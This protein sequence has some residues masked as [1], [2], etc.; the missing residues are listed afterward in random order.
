MRKLLSV[1]LLFILLGTIPTM[2]EDAAP[3]VQGEVRSLLISL[4]GDC[5]IG[6]D[7]PLF[8]AKDSFVGVMRANGNDYTYPLKNAQHLFA[9]DDFTL[10]NLEC[11]LT[12]KSQYI[13][14]S[15][16]TNFRGPKDYVNILTEGSV[17]GVSMSNNHALDFGQGGLNDCQKNLDEAGVLWAYNT[18]PIIYEKNGVKIAVLSF[19][20][21]YMEVYWKWVETEIPRLKS[22]EGCDAVIICLH[23]G[24][25]YQTKHNDEEQTRFAHHAIDYGADLVV[26]THPHV[27]Q[28]IE[29]Y[30]NRVIFYSLGNFS[31][32]GN[33]TPKP[34]SIPTAVMQVNLQFDDSGLYSSQ[35]TIHPYHATGTTPKNNYQPV[36]VTG[37]DAENVMNI[38]QNDTPFTLNPYVEGEGAVQDIIYANK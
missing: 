15:L 3:A 22:E 10:V 8:G 17:E 9:N 37:A 13:N 32:G 30:K 31:F 27:L 23:H 29:V 18:D 1:V 20:R 12:D 6:S 7:N 34:A 16:Y 14:A 25:E 33:N 5:I 11:M 21:Y 28:G 2:A 35:F 24:T 19:R 26:G 38:L 4:A 36:P